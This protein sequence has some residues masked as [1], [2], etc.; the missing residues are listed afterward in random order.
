MFYNKNS[1]GNINIPGATGTQIPATCTYV[2]TITGLTNGDIIT[3]GTSINCVMTGNY[4]T[5]MTCPASIS[6]NIDFV[7]VM[8]ATLV[9]TNSLTIDTSNIP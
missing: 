6:S 4:G 7:Y 5:I 1:G 2:Y 9:Q 8:D 3:F